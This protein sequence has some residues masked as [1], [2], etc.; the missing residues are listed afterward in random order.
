MDNNLISV[1]AVAMMFQGLG[2]VTLIWC[3][4]TV[5]RHKK[6]AAWPGVDGRVLESFVDSDDSHNKEPRI[7]YEY[8]VRDQR[9]V[10]DRI[11]PQGRIATS[12]QYAEQ[13]VDCYP[14]DRPIMVFYNPTNP[15]DSALQKQL[16]AWVAMLKLVAGVVLIVLGTNLEWLT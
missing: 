7:K 1:D 6:V 4:S 16:P 12:G 5:Y 14:V 11:C 15:A 8:R 9:Y 10:S 3:L 2:L 13:L